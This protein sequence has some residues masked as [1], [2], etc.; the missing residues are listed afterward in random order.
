MLGHK[1]EEKGVECT[2]GSITVDVHTL[3]PH[4]FPLTVG[5]IDTFM[6]C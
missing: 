1:E 2:A 4:L 5:D 3:L 6:R